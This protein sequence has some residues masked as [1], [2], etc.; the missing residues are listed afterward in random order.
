MEKIIKI[1]GKN[2]I[3]FCENFD[4]SQLSSIKLGTM[5]KLAIFPKNQK[6]LERILCLLFSRKMYFKVVGNLSNVLFI[7][8]INYPIVVTSKMVD[9]IEIEKRKVT[10]SAG[11]MLTKFC[12]ILRKNE[13][14]GTEGL[15]GIPATIG[16]AIKSN[17]GAFG[18]SISD[19]LESVRVFYLGN[20]FELSKNQ[21]KFGYHYS[22]LEGFIILGATFLFENKNEYDIIKLSNEFAYLRGRSQPS[23]FSLGSVFKKSNGKSAGFYIERSGLKGLRVGGM[24]VSSK[25]SNF[26]INE[27]GGSVI[28]MLRLISKVQSSVEKQ[29]GVTL[30]TEIER[31]GDK[32]EIVG[33]LPYTYKKQ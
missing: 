20:I 10:V 32:D 1:L 14:S 6:E 29:F 2:K 13:L 5:A 26:F 16:G 4:L 7:Q 15:C 18:Y 21:I 19:H 25:H 30:Q 31:V 3:E 33:R 23:G 17:A 28:D 24:V 9:E 12:D 22:N 11:M 27:S 8:N